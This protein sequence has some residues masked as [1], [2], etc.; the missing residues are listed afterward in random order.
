M[1]WITLI[2]D[3]KLNLNIIKATE[4]MAV[5]TVMMFLKYKTDIV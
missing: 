4:S 2:G 5:L 3:E 1:Q